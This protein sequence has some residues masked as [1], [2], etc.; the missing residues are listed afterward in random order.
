MMLVCRL[1]GG[2]VGRWSMEVC[3]LLSCLPILLKQAL[4]TMLV[5][6]SEKLVDMR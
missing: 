6:D 2:W 5:W 4:C 1:I 3:E